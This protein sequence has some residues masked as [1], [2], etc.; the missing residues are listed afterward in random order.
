M[1]NF[2]L[3]KKKRE[4]AQI[5]SKMRGKIIIDTKIIQ[6]ILKDYYEHLFLKNCTWAT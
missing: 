5:K 2:R 4:R 1:T 3:I 6:I